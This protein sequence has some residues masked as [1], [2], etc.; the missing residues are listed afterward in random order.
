MIVSLKL[1]F[2]WESSFSRPKLKHYYSGN[3]AHKLAEVRSAKVQEG[4]AYARLRGMNDLDCMRTPPTVYNPGTRKFN[5]RV[6]HRYRWNPDQSSL[7]FFWRSKHTNTK[8]A[9]Y[10][11]ENISLSQ[12]VGKVSGSSLLKHALSKLSSQEAVSLF[13]KVTRDCDQSIPSNK[14]TILLLEERIVD[15]WTKIHP[16]KL[17]EVYKYMHNSSKERLETLFERRKNLDALPQSFNTDA[18]RRV[19]LLLTR[20]QDT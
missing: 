6:F 19:Q 11:H 5:P 13:F 9:E 10:P 12:N 7:P 16:S 18:G 2:R 20:G 17:M 14:S 15:G 4:P 8:A 3:R 1:S